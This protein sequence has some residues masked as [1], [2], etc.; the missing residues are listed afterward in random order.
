MNRFLGLL[1]LFF[2]VLA[3]LTHS[4]CGPVTDDD[5][6]ESSH[7][8][9]VF[10]MRDVR[11]ARS[12]LQNAAGHAVD[13]KNRQLDAILMLQ[14]RPTGIVYVMQPEDDVEFDSNGTPSCSPRQVPGVGSGILTSTTRLA[15]AHHVVW[16][17][18]EPRFVVRFGGHGTSDPVN[19]RGGSFILDSPA[20]SWD[21]PF[22]VF[23]RFSE[24]FLFGNRLF[25]LGLNDWTDP[26]NMDQVGIREN[27]RIWTFEIDGGRGELV[28][29]AP[30]NFVHQGFVSLQGL[31]AEIRG[32]D[33]AF[34]TST[35]LQRF[36][37]D[38]FPPSGEFPFSNP[39]MF[40]DGWR[41]ATE[42]SMVTGLLTSLR[43][44]GSGTVRLQ[45]LTWGQSM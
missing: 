21:V 44:R 7:S 8:A 32:D 36:E 14:S 41:L 35:G 25:Q 38:D 33:V 23:D 13:S 2:G 43:R 29:G 1:A 24:D 18:E 22:P 31:P 6:L 37:S 12:H 34:L 19:N 11:Q 28:P 27:L 42:M 5:G 3:L 20:Q 4:A 10:G 40:F 30:D 17:F 9:L 26:A 15:T 39:G 16:P 45:A